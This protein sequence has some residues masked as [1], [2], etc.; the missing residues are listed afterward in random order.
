MRSFTDDKKSSISN[1]TAEERLPC[2]SFSGY[3]PSSSGSEQLEYPDVV[4]DRH[5]ETSLPVSSAEQIQSVSQGTGEIRLWRSD[6]KQNAAVERN[7]RRQS[8]NPADAVERNRKDRRLL[9]VEV[10]DEE[11]GDFQTGRRRHDESLG[12]GRITHA[13]DVDSHTESTNP[14]TSP[15]QDC[16]GKLPVHGSTM[17][18]VCRPKSAVDFRLCISNETRS[19]DGD[20]DVSS[21]SMVFTSTSSVYVRSS[22][23]VDLSSG[24]SE[25]VLTFESPKALRL[26]KGFFDSVCAAYSSKSL[27]NEIRFPSTGRQ[28]MQRSSAALRHR[29]AGND[30]V[31]SGSDCA[32][33][34]QFGLGGRRA[35]RC[36]DFQSAC[37]QQLTVDFT[38]IRNS[39]APSA[40][41][42]ASSG[43]MGNECVKIGTSR[44]V[45]VDNSSDQ[46]A[47][48]DGDTGS[49]RDC[50]FCWSTA[51]EEGNAGE[52]EIEAASA[53]AAE[54]M[55]MVMTP[56]TK[57]VTDEMKYTMAEHTENV[58]GNNL[59]DYEGAFYSRDNC[60]DWNDDDDEDDGRVDVLSDDDVIINEEDDR[61]EATETTI[62]I[63]AF[64]AVRTMEDEK[65][66]VERSTNSFY[67]V[68]KH[69]PQHS[70]FV[71]PNDNESSST[72]TDK[73][74]SSSLP[75]DIEAPSCGKDD[76][77][78]VAG[79]IDVETN[80]VAD[81]TDAP[82]IVF[83]VGSKKLDRSSTVRRINVGEEINECGT[84]TKQTAKKCK[85]IARQLRRD[86]SVSSPAS[87][88][89]VMS[90]AGQSTDDVITATKGSDKNRV[91]TT[92]KTASNEHLSPFDT[93][94]MQST[95]DDIIVIGSEE[96]VKHGGAVYML[97]SYEVDETS[98]A[99]MKSRDV[100]D[101]SPERCPTEATVAIADKS[102]TATKRIDG[103]DDKTGSGTVDLDR[104]RH[105]CQEHVTDVSNM[106]EQGKNQQNSR[107]LT[108][109]VEK[110]TNFNTKFSMSSKSSSSSI[111]SFHSTQ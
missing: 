44:H 37:D 58:D 81:A 29:Q 8:T 67:H 62:M 69:D 38:G 22:S 45:F 97:K 14:V 52:V 83:E 23:L 76:C 73:E 74:V 18:S 107:V 102:R 26:A 111:R 57:A 82:G 77:S 106:S 108:S 100:I 33:H 70:I 48:S 71:L 84:S 92:R 53:A 89:C 25:P 85:T 49:D 20:V 42:S 7:R 12:R 90:C 47:S 34:S 110:L 93:P 54:K 36:A 28:T 86:V 68:S 96:D 4:V 30:A 55:I 101:R 10:D 5:N 56:D 2:G 41:R 98:R 78:P 79:T 15:W 94:E 59:P 19:S 39:R 17:S 103:I 16:D 43:S 63:A 27:D 35:R 88:N 75:V 66:A 50:S 91:I 6:K 40:D 1:T 99:R 46:R 51:A 3:V 65:T 95:E 21:R 60:D 13:N 64:E 24:S 80:H 105:R 11:D 104:A 61:N 109:G 32:R 31:S 72:S 87:V 9:V